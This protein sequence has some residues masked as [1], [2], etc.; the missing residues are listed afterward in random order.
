MFFIFLNYSYDY[1][2]TFW[3][4]KGGLFTCKCGKANCSFSDET[5]NNLHI[6]SDNEEVELD[7]NTERNITENNEMSNKDLI[8]ISGTDKNVLQDTKLSKND[9]LLEQVNE[10]SCSSSSESSSTN[11]NRSKSLN[12]SP[13]LKNGLR[14]KN[15][16]LSPNIVKKN[17]KNVSKDLLK[18]IDSHSAK[19]L[20]SKLIQSKFQPV[21]LKK[22][23]AEK[24]LNGNSNSTNGGPPLLTT[25]PSK[26]KSSSQ[27]AEK[28]K[29][30]NGNKISVESVQSTK[31]V[32]PYELRTKVSSPDK[33][34]SEN[35]KTKDR[36]SHDVIFRSCDVRNNREVS[37]SSDTSSCNQNTAKDT[38][39]CIKLIDLVDIKT[40]P[41]DE[42][43][44]TELKLVNGEHKSAETSFT[45]ERERV[46]VKP[47]E[48]LDIKRSCKK[49]FPCSDQN[50]WSSIDV[51][52]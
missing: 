8:S 30:C 33:K 49:D 36:V 47:G 18:M 16:S 1:G 9:N 42:E 21:I 5:I 35:T 26:K 12:S 44:D 3:K 45:S 29:M 11:P 39:D 6:D 17:G 24:M 25:V 13:K 37:V 23:L 2:T 10:H 22:G 43:S 14:A 20:E 19:V 28:N 46:K 27:V 4:V 31:T 50:N 15:K 48:I 41:D 38:N 32:K 51:I 7:G 52:K 40:E 34:N